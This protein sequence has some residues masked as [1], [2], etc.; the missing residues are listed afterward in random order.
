MTVKRDPLDR[1]FDIG[2]LAIQTAGTS[3]TTQAEQ[4][5]VGLENPQAVYELAVRALRRFRGAMS[6]TAADV[7][8]EDL[9]LAILEE[10]R[11]IR[12]SLER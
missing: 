11:G 1:L 4:R 2:S 8:E 12:E 7:D 6:P 5:L 10:V 3:G 9:L